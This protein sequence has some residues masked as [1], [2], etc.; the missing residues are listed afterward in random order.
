[1]I[2]IFAVFLCFGSNRDVVFVS[3]ILPSIP[4]AL[5]TVFSIFDSGK[6]GRSIYVS[7]KSCGLSKWLWN[8]LENV[9][10]F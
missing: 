10:L 9:F 6:C 3:I 8:S 5:D 7:W 2:L 1:M 4:S